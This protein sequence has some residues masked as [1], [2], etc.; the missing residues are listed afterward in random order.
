MKFVYE[1][2]ENVTGVGDSCLMTSVLDV[3]ALS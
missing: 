2:V 1:E 3:I